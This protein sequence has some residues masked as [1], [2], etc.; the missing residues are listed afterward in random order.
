MRTLTLALV[1]TAACAAGARGA[2]GASSPL[3]RLRR[4]AP[5]IRQDMRYAGPHNFIGRPIKGYRAAEC[6]LT[7]P[8]A[9]A[10]R[11]VQADLA[12][13]GLSLKV[14][15]C[16]RPQR[17]VDDFVAWA[18]DLS[19]TKMKT[20]FYPSVDKADLFKDGY[21]AAKSGHS[22]GST[23][24]LTIVASSG[25]AQARYQEG[26][27]LV[28]CTRP[29]GERFR[30]DSLDMGG[31]YDCFDPLSRTASLAPGPS[32][33][34]SRLLLKT[35]MEKHGFT[36]LPEEWWHFTLNGEPYPDRSFDLPVE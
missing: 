2:D 35:V 24:D 34:A 30:D 22:R 36:N 18:K 5:T 4:V 7:R 13:A 19:D 21:I 12:A 16:Y 20:E 8:A 23:M 27:A 15:D 9:E 17:A 6:L 29:V 11:A 1:W 31:G 14:Y 28:G 32:Q 3:V 25:P 26:D 33:R 10:L